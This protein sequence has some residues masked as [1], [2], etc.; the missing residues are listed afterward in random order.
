M[1]KGFG[2][3]FF[4]AL[5]WLVVSCNQK[6]AETTKAAKQP[7]DT[8]KTKLT[9]LPPPPEKAE[10]PTQVELQKQ[11]KEMEKTLYASEVLD[12]DKAKRMIRLYDTYHKNYYMDAACPD[13]LFKAGE[14]SENINQFN[15]AA[16]F[17]KM[18]CYEY[19]DNFKY[20]S[21]C[22]FRL[23]NVYDYKLNDYIHAK[24]VYTQIKEQYP[25]TQLATDADAAIKMMGQSDKDIV[26]GFERK[27][28]N[29]K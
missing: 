3:L 23:A 26:R 16:Q 8:S 6:E 5:T 29:T 21:L 24:E 4:I 2:V 22:L 27:N 28:A 11:I 7:A 1:K 12:V 14:I 9:E 18:C 10:V 17:Y 20:R 25:K 15:R 19:N 13:Y